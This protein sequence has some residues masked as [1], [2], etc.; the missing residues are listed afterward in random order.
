M[1]DQA[2]NILIGIFVIVACAIIVF[3]LMFLHPSVGDESRLLRVRFA[4]I[5]K[6]TLGTRVNFAGKPVG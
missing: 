2:K 1:P 5:D 6:I 4:N 3:V